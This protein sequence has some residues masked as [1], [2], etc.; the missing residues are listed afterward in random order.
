MC[1]SEIKKDHWLDHSEQLFG[2]QLVN[3]TKRILKILV[4][5]LPLFIFWALLNQQ[6]SRWVFQASLMN[7]DLGWYTVKPDQMV[8]VG[9]FLILILLPL[10]N[11]YIFPFLE[12]F[13]LKTPLQ[14]MGVGMFL[15]GVTFLCS[16]YVEHL[17][18]QSHISILW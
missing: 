4:I 3:D 5:Y 12:K 18:H 9:P 6:M 11:K 2:S 7:G 17:I 1:A 8:V 16:A 13:R 15:A 14:K 10:F